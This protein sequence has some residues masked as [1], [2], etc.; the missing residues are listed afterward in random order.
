MMISPGV[1]TVGFGDFDVLPVFPPD[2]DIV[3]QVPVLGPGAHLERV[4]VV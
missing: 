3:D 1:S 2:S 4:I